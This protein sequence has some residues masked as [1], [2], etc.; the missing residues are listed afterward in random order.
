MKK[1]YKIVFLG[2]T[3]VGKTTLISQYLYNKTQMSTPTIGID[4]LSTTLEVDKCPVRL[5]LWDT[6]GQERFQSIIGN[7]TRNTFLAIIVYA[8]DNKDSLV[9]VRQWVEGFV[10][11]HNSKKDVRLLIV[12]NKNDLAKEGFDPDFEEGRQM[13]ESLEA[14]FVTTNALETSGIVEMIEAINEIIRE[15]MKTKNE[16]EDNEDKNNIIITRSSS[17]CC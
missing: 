5:Q 14:K 17:R 12:A 9:K 4:F 13:A 16:N 15:D 1:A 6:A 11:T 8:V 2:N 10:Y 3:S 7:Y